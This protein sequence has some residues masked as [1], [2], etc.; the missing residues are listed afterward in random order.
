MRFVHL[1]DC[2]IGGWQDPKLKELGISAFKEAVARCIGKKVDFVLISG[3]LFDSAIPQI[4]L[5]KEVAASLN[6]LK[7]EGI[8]VYIIPGSHDFSPSGKTMLEVLEKAELCTNVVKYGG[9]NTLSFTLDKTTGA[10]ITGLLGKK[11]GLEKADY[12]TLDKKNLEEEQGFKIFMFHTALEEFK[13][14]NMEDMEAQSVASLPKNFD[15]YAGGHVHYI[16]HKKEGNSLLTFPGALFPNNFKE[17]EEF[18]HGGFYL[19]D[20]KLNFSY[21]PVK[22][23]DVISLTFDAENKTPHQVEEDIKK[24]L[25]INETKDKIVTLRID[26][27][28]SSGNPSDINFK[29][30]FEQLKDAYF[31]MKNT[32]KLSVKKFVEKEV[33]GTNVEEVEKNILQEH[34]K[35]AGTKLLAADKEK[36]VLELMATLDKEKGEGEKT[37]DFEKRIISEAFEVLKIRIK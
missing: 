17:L 32:N 6:K 3:D 15:Y 9:E 4:E 11:G 26:G 24:E 35:V 19:V 5:I 18:K 1:A 22:T 34:L 31:V 30:I 16:F 33:E 12:A 7:K 36:L 8:P 37:A 14:K 21:E 10:K 29:K 28:L 2:H 25:E 20:D 27:A 13:P 23:K